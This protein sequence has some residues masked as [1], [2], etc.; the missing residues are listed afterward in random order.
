[1]AA[2]SGVHFIGL[3]CDQY[4][5]IDHAEFVATITG[6][7]AWEAIIRMKPAIVFGRGSFGCHD[8]VHPHVFNTAVALK[9]YIEA[10][11]ASDADFD[12]SVATIIEFEQK[13]Y[14]CGLSPSEQLDVYPN[15][16]EHFRSCFVRASLNAAADVASARITSLAS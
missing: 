13:N 12:R 3:E 16:A 10:L 7:A 9:S 11:P 8:T 14:Y 5:L 15:T 6:S 4:D 1:L 2:I